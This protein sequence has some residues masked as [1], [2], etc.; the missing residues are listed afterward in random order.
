MVD[1]DV[2]VDEETVR[3]MW[4]GYQC[5]WCYQIFK[6]AWP[7]VCT[8]PGCG[9]SVRAKQRAEMERDYQ[10]EDTELWKMPP[11]EPVEERAK[12]SGIWVPKSI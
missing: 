9:Y 12:R 1:V 3:R 6:E 11:D 2:T 4:Q 10:G 7:E 5:K 8:F